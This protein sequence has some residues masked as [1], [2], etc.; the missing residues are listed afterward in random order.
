L[1]ALTVGR[2]GRDLAI[3]GAIALGL[4]VLAQAQVWTVADLDGNRYAIAALSLALA[5]SMLLR[6]AYPLVVVGCVLAYFAVTAVAG[7]NTPDVTF[8]PSAALMISA[9]SVAAHGDTRTGLLGA[10]LIACVPLAGFLA[11]DLSIVEVFFM[12]LF[13]AASWSAG[14]LV[15]NREEEARRI[16]HRSAALEREAEE[17]TRAAVAEERARIARELH[18]VV[19]HGLSGMVFEAAGAERVLERDPE[20]AREALHSIRTAGTDAAAE[21]HRLLGMMRSAPADGSPD[22]LPTLAGVDELVERARRSGVEVS[23]ATD[24]QLDALPAGLQLAAYRIVQEGLTNVLKHA[25]GA[26]ARVALRQLPGRLEVEVVDS[27][28]ARAAP[29]SPLGHGLV[30]MRERVAV[31][32]GELET[33][34]VQP[35]G[36]RV[37]ARFPLANAS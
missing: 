12:L 19:S 25:P 18:D 37:L 31:Y 13:N 3:D 2:R 32:G 5:F 29:T 30:G 33:G 23:F 21:L 24:G 28:A 6:R 10:G 9:D 26:S 36:F 7:W 20:R 15:R 27:G 17:R 14:Q 22:A 35:A 8:F 11:G 4:G 16:G 34:P 1:A